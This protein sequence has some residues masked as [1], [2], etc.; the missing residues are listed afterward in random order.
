MWKWFQIFRRRYAKTAVNV[1]CESPESSSCQHVP[2]TIIIHH[3]EFVTKDFWMWFLCLHICVVVSCICIIIFVCTRLLY[4]MWKAN[5][6]PASAILQITKGYFLLAAAVRNEIIPLEMKLYC[7]S[8]V[9][10]HFGSGLEC[11]VS[12]I[13]RILLWQGV[14]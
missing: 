8:T 12:F 13:D 14:F 10:R 6:R 5:G 3:D 2:N 4:F 9:D 1:K 11:R 7:S